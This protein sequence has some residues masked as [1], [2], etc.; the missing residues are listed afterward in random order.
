MKVIALMPVKN[1][2]WILPTT[3]PQLQQFV[4]EIL[5]LDTGSTD[6]SQEILAKLGVEVKTGFYDPGHCN[7]Y[8]TWRNTLLRWGRERQGSHFVWLDAD[9]TFSSHFLPSFWRHLNQLRPGQKL[10]LDWLCLWKSPY[11]LRT[12]ACVWKKVSKDF[13]ICDDGSSLFCEADYLHGSRTPGLNDPENRTYIPRSEG[14]ILHYQFVPFSRFQMKQAF[15]RIF[16]FLKKTTEHEENYY[17]TAL[18]INRNY[19]ITLDD[20][21]ACCIP[22]PSEWYHG[23]PHLNALSEAPAGWY[24][25]AILDF[26]TRK[27][28]DWFEPLQIWHIPTLR[29]KFKKEMGREPISMEI[30]R[31]LKMKSYL[32]H[33]IINPFIQ[34]LQGPK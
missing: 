3:I 6:G 28:I 8:A 11:F 12:D 9:E 16:E 1:E 18:L 26:F 23:I 21:K 20:P 24:E 19:G 13:V 17:K 2:A 34:Y 5:V 22:L 29:E 33:R 30:P 25:E 14:S 10:F 4:D 31:M 32:R 7:N 15:Y 27:P